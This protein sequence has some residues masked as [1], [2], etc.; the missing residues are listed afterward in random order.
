[1]ETDFSV[2]ALAYAVSIT[3]LIRPF[4]VKACPNLETLLLDFPFELRTGTSAARRAKAAFL[5]A[6]GLIDDA[7]DDAL[8]SVVI[9][10]HVQLTQQYAVKSLIEMLDS[11]DVLGSLEDVVMK[12]KAVK[13]MRIVFINHLLTNR[14]LDEKPPEIEQVGNGIENFL[15]EKMSKL[16]SRGVLLR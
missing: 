11:L 3:E 7:S 4:N 10:V 16:A 15:K 6:T 9:R 8:R 12:K 14:L 2:V 5:L 1:V 13:D